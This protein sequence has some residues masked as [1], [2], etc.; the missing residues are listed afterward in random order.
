MLAY[1]YRDNGPLTI[2]RLYDCNHPDDDSVTITFDHTRPHHT[3]KF[4][5]SY[6]DHTVAGFFPTAYAP[7]DPS[8]LFQQ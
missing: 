2:V 3:T 7:K 8:P 4:S 1:G 5:Y 6:D